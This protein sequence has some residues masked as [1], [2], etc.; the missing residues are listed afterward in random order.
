[1]AGLTKQDAEA[2]AP[3]AQPTTAAPVVPQAP[4]PQPGGDAADVTPDDL[5]LASVAAAVPSLGASVMP[6]VDPAYTV[7]ARSGLNLRA[8]PG[9][10]FPVIG[11]LPLGARVHVVKQDGAWA[12][13]D[14]MGDG[15]A[16]GHV[17]LS[18]L[19]KDAA[20]VP[21]P[22]LGLAGAATAGPAA[23]RGGFVTL[24]VSTLQTIMNRC[25]GVRIRSKLDLDQV[26]YA[27]NKSM[28]L[29]NATT[30]LREVAFLSQAVI[31]TD[32]FRTFAEYGAGRGKKYAPYYGRG[33]H[34]LTWEDTYRACSRAVYHDDRL[35]DDP[36]L[37][38]RDIEVNVAATAWY[39]RDHKPFNSLADVRDID[40]IIHL[41]YGGTINS[42]NPDV[43]RSV[44]LRRGYYATI[45]SILG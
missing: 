18:F 1:M 40:A 29:A 34:Q 3:P 26:V 12:L 25:A 38:L 7:I 4:M 33:I 27:L 22:A 9:V 24:D 16:D 31:E 21:G 17:L 35:F 28:S 30:L 23:A 36:D 5:A 41:L 45:G 39:W 20:A 44:Q 8:G 14:G 37:V 11:S 19:R 10:E 32:Y 42:P 6:A 13:V 15:A 2:A 43:R